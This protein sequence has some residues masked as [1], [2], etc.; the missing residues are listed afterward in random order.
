MRRIATQRI[1]QSVDT[2]DH[3]CVTESVFSIH[4]YEYWLL[5]FLVINFIYMTLTHPFVVLSFRYQLHFWP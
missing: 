2:D 1:Q 4:V 3:G 5:P